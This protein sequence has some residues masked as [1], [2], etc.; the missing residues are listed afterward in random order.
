MRR[1]TPLTLLFAALGLI[2][3]VVGVIYLTTKA[4][5]LPSFFPG[6][7]AHAAHPGKYTKRAAASFAAAVVFF[8]VSL[9]AF[10][11]DRARRHD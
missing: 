8:I 10:R 7:L 4:T 11:Y 2:A 5:D 6:H 9:L 3:V 1:L